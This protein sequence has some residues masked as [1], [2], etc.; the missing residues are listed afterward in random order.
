MSTCLCCGSFSFGIWAES[1]FCSRRN[2]ST[3]EIS[4]RGDAFQKRREIDG[5]TP[6]AAVLSDFVDVIAN[7]LKIKHQKDFAMR[8]CLRVAFSTQPHSPTLAVSPQLHCANAATCATMPLAYRPAA[9]ISQVNM[10]VRTVQIVGVLP[11][12]Q[13]ECIESQQAL[14]A[15]HHGM[16]PPSRIQHRRLRTPR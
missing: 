6:V 11:P 7:I 10:L 5:D 16:E 14:E 2:W 13:Q 3:C 4:S 1:S 8:N 15:C 12:A 9:K